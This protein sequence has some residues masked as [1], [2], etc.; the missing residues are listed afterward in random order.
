[1]KTVLIAGAGQL[2]SRHLQ[3]VKLSANELDIWVYD[4]SAESLKVAEERYN[5]VESPTEKTAHF[6]QSL[7]EVPTDIDVTIVASSSKPR[8]AIV[9]ELLASH[10][11][12]YMVL[13]KFLF[14]RMSD[15]DEIAALLKEKNV[16]TFV[17][18]PRRMFESF[19]V[20]KEYIDATKPVVMTKGGKDWGLCCNSIH[21][22]DI[23]M[24]LT[25]EA[26]YTL[27]VDGIIP[28]V[29]D[30]KRGG[31]VELR[32][33]EV[34]ETPNGSRLTL[35]ST[36]DYDG[37]TSLIIKN[38]DTSIILNEGN[39]DVDINGK[40]YNT[41]VKYQS[42]LSGIVVDDLLAIGTCPLTTYDDSARYHKPFLSIIAPLINKL[43]GWTSDSCPIT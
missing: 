2:G 9:T 37:D 5:Q 43:K 28:E 21:F 24:Y 4:L 42:G 38:G 20:V 15:Y 31:Y 29:V 12:K 35:T 11:V 8:Y 17:N 14:P 19:S 36:V 33:T 16:T 40:I 1:M 41:A 13:E 22:I 10:N 6:V 7:S 27:N 39:G 18:C 30:S 3:G 26:D 32:G 23:F 25:G 34:I